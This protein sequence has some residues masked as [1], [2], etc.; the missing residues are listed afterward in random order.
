[1]WFMG[2][3]ELLPRLFADER[4]YI[5]AHRMMKSI[6][7]A[8]DVRPGSTSRRRPY[9]TAPTHPKTPEQK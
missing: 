1:M 3:S 5:A 9:T 2:L 7:F 4:K 6:S 8:L